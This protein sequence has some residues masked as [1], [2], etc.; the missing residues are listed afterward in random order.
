MCDR[1]LPDNRLRNITH[2]VVTLVV[3]LLCFIPSAL[4][5]GD[6]Y[7]QV[8]GL[9]DLRT[10][11]SDGEHELED[12]VKLAKERGFPV[13]ILN[14]HDRMAMEY[15]IAPLRH[16]IKKKVEKPSVNKLGP[17]KYL[18]AVSAINKKYPDMLVIPG[19]E[20]SPFYYWTGNPFKGG[21]T[22]NDWEKHILVMGLEKAEDVAGLPILHNG[23]STAY[24]AE[25][26]LLFV[27][28]LLVAAIGIY[29]ITWGGFFRILGMLL[30]I[31]G[32]AFAW[33]VDAFRS[34]PYD[35]YHG[36][37]G[38]DP[39]QHLIDYVNERGGVT[40]WN[41]PETKSGVGKKPPIQVNTPPYPEVLVQ[42]I[43]YTGFASLYGDKITIT[44][45]GKAWDNLL[46]E[47]CN[48]KRLK[49]AWGISTADYHEEGHAGEELGNFPTV[50]LVKEFSKKAIIEALRNGK[51]YASQGKYKK[52][53]V[54]EE[55]T[56]TDLILE[57]S[58]VSGD[59][60]K[61]FVPALI[62][63]KV[64]SIDENS[65][66]TKVRLIR[67][68]ELVKSFEGETPMIIDFEDEYFLEGK[69]GYYRIDVKGA[70]G[71]VVSNP[72]FVSW[73]KK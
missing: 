7:R 20:S 41:H 27:L 52:R 45:P 36:N 23:F 31:L 39:Y 65:Y 59:E 33:N 67:N 73:A 4:F 66:K 12:V 54:L 29:I 48:G 50:F 22:A 71:S 30:L 13:L 6:G 47:Y 51:M 43:N 2:K 62:R 68:G 60:V 63:I 5:A 49:P 18:D 53:A 46:L 58:G 61:L 55:F 15:G 34:S 38:I 28:F 26:L 9:I 10:T 44:E 14:D 69:K 64:K 37:Q 40:F 1:I 57:R 72:I 16:I 42:S 24:I 8:A 32:L 17:Q 11:Y 70:M 25:H 3:L 56:V 19:L 21:L 35:Q